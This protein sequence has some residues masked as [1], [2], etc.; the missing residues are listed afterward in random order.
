MVIATEYAVGLCSLEVSCVCHP[1]SFYHLP[2]VACMCF[3]PCIL[4]IKVACEPG[5]GCCMKSCA[6]SRCFI[7]KNFG[8][9]VTAELHSNHVGCGVRMW[10]LGPGMWTLGLLIRQ[11]C[12][13]AVLY[14]GACCLDHVSESVRIHILCIWCITRRMPCDLCKVRW[15]LADTAAQ[16]C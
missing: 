4:P 2:C 8:T 15:P 1:C 6:I 11:T 14:A 3:L 10:P 5:I 9:L 7:Y 12:A 13:A 16:Q